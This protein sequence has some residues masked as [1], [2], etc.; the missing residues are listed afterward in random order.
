MRTPRGFEAVMTN[1]DYR[2]ER[3][4]TG[5]DNVKLSP[6][7]L[8]RAYHGPYPAGPIGHIICEML[9]RRSHRS[10]ALEAES[11]IDPELV[12]RDSAGRAPQ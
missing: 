5:F 11:V 3:H 12:M 7:L 9:L 8:S 4:L 6:V 1:T 10:R 2:A